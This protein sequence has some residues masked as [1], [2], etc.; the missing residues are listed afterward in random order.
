MTAFA[1]LLADNQ[2]VNGS[3]PPTIWANGVWFQTLDT[4]QSKAWNGDVGGTW[5]SAAT[6]TMAGAGMWCCGPWQISGGG[7]LIN[8]SSS[9]V[10]LTHGDNDYIVLQAGHA[11]ATRTLETSFSLGRDISGS[12]ARMVYSNTYDG[13]I[14]YQIGG[15][16]VSGARLALPIDVHNG[17]TFSQVVFWFVIG[18]SHLPQSQPFFRVVKVD[19]SGN[20][21]PLKSTGLTQA[22][23]WVQLAAANA[24]AYFA[25]GV[26]QSFTYTLDGGVVVDTSAFSYFAEI[27][28][29]DGTSAAGGNVYITAVATMTSIPDMRPQ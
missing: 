12:T 26:A 10:R 14:N 25:G 11:G 24:G 29:E 3:I 16:F 27:V 9:G 28:D 18:S 20:V 6:L 23:G 17:A 15:T 21:T 7:Q 13:L 22:G 19:G 1:R 5:T 4:N 8:P 2:Y